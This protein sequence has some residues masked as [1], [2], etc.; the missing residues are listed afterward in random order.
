MQRWHPDDLVGKLLRE[1]REGGDQWEKVE[2][3]AIAEQDEKYRKAGEAL[4]PPRY[5]V[6]E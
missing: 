5:S 2:Y 4:H 1:M 3:Q 6:E